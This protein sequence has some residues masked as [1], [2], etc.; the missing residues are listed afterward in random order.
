MQA[1]G[2]QKSA[3]FV[4]LGNRQPRHRPLK[5]FHVNWKHLVDQ[6][7]SFRRQLAEYDSRIL[8]ACS[9]PHQATLLELLHDIRR[10]GAGHENPVPNLA[11]WQGTLVIQHLQHGELSQAQ[12]GLNQMRPYRSLDRL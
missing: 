4:L 9:P 8:G 1:E 5:P 2:P 11:K 6:R 7:P 10:T 12:S 3:C